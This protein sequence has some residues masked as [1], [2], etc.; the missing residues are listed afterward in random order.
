MQLCVGDA[1]GE[2]VMQL[3][4]QQLVD[5]GAP[6]A[7]LACHRAPGGAARGAWIVACLLASRCGFSWQGLR[8]LRAFDWLGRQEAVTLITPQLVV[9]NQPTLMQLVELVARCVCC[10]ASCAKR[11]ISLGVVEV[12]SGLRM[13]RPA[14]CC[15][16]SA[17]R[18]RVNPNGKEI[19]ASAPPQVLVSAISALSSRDDGVEHTVNLC[20]VILNCLTVLLQPPTSPP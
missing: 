13:P 3:A 18:R 8:R 17:A 1:A 6:E 12:R 16:S 5:A 4:A 19:T 10:A 14:R 11:L 7:L 9:A 15:V 20:C 2:S